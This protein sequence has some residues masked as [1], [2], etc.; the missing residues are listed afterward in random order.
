M[1]RERRASANVL[2]DMA[3]TRHVG[4]LDICLVIVVLIA[5]AIPARTMYARD[6]F[7][8][9]DHLEL[10]RAE[11]RTIV[12]PEH[13]GHVEQLI[14]KLGENG[15][16]DWAI[17]VGARGVDA[18]RDHAQHWRALVAASVAHV[19]RLEAR[20]AFTLAERALA[21]CI[22]AGASAC[23]STERVRLEIFHDHLAAGIE[24]STF[25]EHGRVT[26]PQDFRKASER[27]IRNIRL[28]DAPRQ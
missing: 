27:K 16:T 1:Q 4:I 3:L 18:S 15:F 17:A 13:G 7:A 5:V 10:A 2:G 28:R 19:D 9:D 23:S 12:N 25:D 6:A 8:P 11:A 26:N 22:E 24:V 14:Y 20:T 21:A